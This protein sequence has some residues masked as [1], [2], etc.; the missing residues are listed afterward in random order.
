MKAEEFKFIDKQIELLQATLFQGM[1]PEIRQNLLDSIE[2]IRKEYEEAADKRDD[3]DADEKTRKYY[4]RICESI[5]KGLPNI[6]KGTLAAANAFNKGDYMNGTAAIMD[7]CSAAAPIIGSLFTAGGPPGALI[8]ALFSVVGQLL[9]FFGPKQPSLKDQIKDMMLGLEAETT[10]RTMLSVGDSID[11]YADKLTNAATKHSDILKLPLK[12]ETDA[13]T[14]Q[15]KCRALEIGLALN[16]NQMTTP[17]FNN[18][19]VMEW[20]RMKDRQALEKWPEV[21]S[22]FC[23]SYIKLVNANILFSC[24]LDRNRIHALLKGTSEEN[25]DSSSL[26][27]KARDHVHQLL[28]KL[29]AM[30][31]AFC[32]HWKTYNQQ[33]LKL[34]ADIEQAARYRGLFVIVG[35]NGYLYAGSG[36]ANIVNDAKWTYLKTSPDA[37]GSGYGYITRVTAA[38]SWGDVDSPH[39]PYHCFLLRPKDE[40]EGGDVIEHRIIMASTPPRNTASG[41]CG[42]TV[43]P[44]GAVRMKGFIYGPDSRGNLPDVKDLWAIPGGSLDKPKEVWLYVATEKRIVEMELTE[45]REMVCRGWQSQP[46]KGYLT[47]VRSVYPSSVPDDPDGDIQ[48]V[49][50]SN[51]S[52]VD[53]MVDT[54]IHYGGMRN[55]SDIFV[56][57]HGNGS[58]GYVS[59]PWTERHMVGEGADN[60]RG[61]GVDN[62]FLWAFGPLGFACATHSSV[63]KAINEGKQPRWIEH[64]PYK[65]LFKLNGSPPFDG[66]IP[67]PGLYETMFS[68]NMEKSKGLVDLAPC[69]DG[70]LTANLFTRD[71]NTRKNTLH[72][73]GPGMY[74]ASYQVDIKAG[75]IQV[76]NWT[77][78]RGKAQQVLKMPIYCWPM[79]KSL[80]AKLV[81]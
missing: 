76:G 33:V 43:T 39:T 64:N 3:A 62:Q 48:S 7:I 2:D 4:E 50:S 27:P 32:E 5:A 67:D 57:R 8:G 37:N 47:K 80:K 74:M 54:L 38:L 41:I 66:F 56:V 55:S 61:I 13:D 26:P 52:K 18:W 81:A 22:V 49:F 15:E 19:E 14:F 45:E 79:L 44:Q 23:K 71:F 17:A 65:L 25:M 9:A 69:D 30:V 31:L 29:N 58:H 10:L 72:D 63:I 24:L 59:T 73:E 60:Y 20:L 42:K 70:T 77:R 36:Q 75:M 6:T 16:E 11:V 34:L 28:I 46:A 51:G 68:G 21:L 78:I 53:T 1:S 40:N 35:S 12:T